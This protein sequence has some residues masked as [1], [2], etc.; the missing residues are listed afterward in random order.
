MMKNTVLSD[1]SNLTNKDFPPMDIYEQV[2]LMDV[3]SPKHYVVARGVEATEALSGL[4]NK[5]CTIDCSMAT[6]IAY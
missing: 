3:A 5:F 2:A 4:R 6:Q 1:P